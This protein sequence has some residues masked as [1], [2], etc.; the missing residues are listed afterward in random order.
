MD[1]MAFL[2]VYIK[3]QD[4]KPPPLLCH[5]VSGEIVLIHTPVLLLL[6]LLHR[7]L[8]LLA[9]GGVHAPDHVLHLMLQA[10]V[11]SPRVSS[12][13]HLS[14]LLTSL[15]TLSRK[16]MN[17]VCDLLTLSVFTWYLPWSSSM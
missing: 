11:P 13:A 14:P 16:K 10:V 5:L 2:C 7:A 6:L 9:L 8:L 12:A 17:K 3:K 1:F 4:S 15:R